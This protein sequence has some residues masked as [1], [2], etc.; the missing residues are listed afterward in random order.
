[1]FRRDELDG[2]VD[3]ETIME[4]KMNTEN[5]IKIF[6]LNKSEVKIE[7]YVVY[8]YL[9]ANEFDKIT[10]NDIVK[11]SPEVLKS[12]PALFV[13]TKEINDKL[14]FIYRKVDAAPLKSLPVNVKIATVIKNVN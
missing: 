14:V 7:D 3:N 6:T 8:L 5:N 2:L 10:D 11:T 4:N 13:E 9:Y 1:M 12:S